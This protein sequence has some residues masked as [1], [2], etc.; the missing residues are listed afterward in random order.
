MKRTHSGSPAMMVHRWNRPP[1]SCKPCREKK[2][3]C[4]RNQPCSNCTQRDTQCEYAGQSQPNPVSGDL[5]PPEGT[6]ID[7]RQMAAS[8]PAA[9]GNALPVP[10]SLNAKEVLHRLQKLEE[11]VFQKPVENNL[12]SV[13]QRLTSDTTNKPPHVGFTPLSAQNLSSACDNAP[14]DALELARHLPP[15]EEATDL[16]NHF[17]ATVGSTFGVLHLP[18]T[19]EL[20]DQTYQCILAARE[21]EISRLLLLFGIFAGSMLSWTPQLLDKLH[22]TPAEANAAFKAY[23]SLAVS[24]VDHPRPM[25]PSTTALAAMETLSHIITNYDGYPFKI[26]LIRFRCHLMARAMQIHRLDTPKS[27]EERRLNG[28]NMIEIEVQRRVWWN[29]VATDWLHSFS[30]GPLEGSYMFQ[31]KQMMVDYPSNVDDEYITPTGILHEF[32]LSKPS[33]MS[34]FIYRVKLSTLCREVVD[35][36]PSIWLE[37]QEPDYETILML[38]KKFQNFL[39]ELPIFFQLD[40]ASIAQSQEICKDRPYIPIQRISIHFGLHA[41][42]CRLH[43]PYHLEG[44]TNTKYAYSHQV[45]IQSAQK[46]L[47]LRRL[48]DDAGAQVGLK[49]ARFWTVMQ[50]VFLAALT[51]ATDVSFNPNAP[52]AEAR[53]A[54]VLAAYQILERS[55]EES[56]MIV[57]A[58]QKNM[59]VLMS[60]LQK[61]RTPA[62]GS[63]SGEPPSEAVSNN[64]NGRGRDGIFTTNQTVDTLSF[65]SQDPFPAA[66][67]PVYSNISHEA[68]VEEGDWDQLLSNFLAVAPD[69]DVPQWHSLLD[70]IDFTFIS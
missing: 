70:D 56:A 18:S 45:C 59:Q 15:I 23:A 66:D 47:E 14:L 28:C 37:A 16:F 61:Q 8:R 33:S 17:V 9:F 4:D 11:A 69:L 2:R 25:E 64:W 19:R 51:L 38:D 22:A 52:D 44:M 62:I 35:T 50:H 12:Q 42:L 21:P 5:E 36:M 58:I 30:G 55:K 20:M 49:P 3:R 24:I 29:M 10:I 7:H 60:T 34:S 63:Q 48:M 39:A 40:P 57:E 6:R 26:H 53:K 13:A 31:P 54:K 32:P 67:G 46:V 43:R 1:L 65:V 27:R 68:C 41:R